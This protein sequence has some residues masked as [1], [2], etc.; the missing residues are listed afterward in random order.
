M[1]DYPAADIAPAPPTPAARLE[2]DAIRFA[3]PAAASV[4]VGVL[5]IALTWVYLPAISVQNAFTA[6]VDV[7]GLLFA[8]FYI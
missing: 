6:V 1:T 7:S 3:T 5:F 2:P 8:A 4:L